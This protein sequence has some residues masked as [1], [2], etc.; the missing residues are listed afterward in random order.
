MKVY[1]I[2]VR[3]PF[4]DMNEILYTFLVTDPKII[5]YLWLS[6]CMPSTRDIKQRNVRSTNI[7][8]YKF[9]EMQYKLYTCD[10]KTTHTPILWFSV[11][12]LEGSKRVRRYGWFQ[13]E[14]IRVCL[15]VKIFNFFSLRFLVVKC[16]LL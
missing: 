6:I 7:C 10:G 9:K 4:K 1:A 8:R 12:K 2:V 11:R 5:D 14:F 16:F 15:K 3:S 13:T